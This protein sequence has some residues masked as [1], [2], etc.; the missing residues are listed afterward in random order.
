MKL[1]PIVTQ[2]SRYLSFGQVVI[3]HS[4]PL[5]SWRKS[6]L[7]IVCYESSIGDNLPFPMLKQPRHEHMTQA[8]Q[9]TW[10]SP[11][12]S[13]KQMILKCMQSG[14]GLLLVSQSSLGSFNTCSS[15]HPAILSSSNKP[16]FG[17][18]TD[19]TS[20]YTEHV[21]EARA[22]YCSLLLIHFAFLR[23]TVFSQLAFRHVDPM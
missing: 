16:M 11:I 17:F 10:S 6:L 14:R 21:L 23:T 3:R 13:H 19:G 1:L 7:H 2:L 8:Q 12:L 22:P 20:R 15:R 4:V 9:I 18:K 5:P